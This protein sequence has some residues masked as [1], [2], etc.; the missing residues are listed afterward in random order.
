MK[1]SQERKLFRWVHIILSIPIFGYIY[2]PLSENIQATK[3]IRGF[4][5]PV[6]FITGL[7]MWKGQAIKRWFK[8]KKSFLVE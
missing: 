5:V 7:W 4:C 8:K 6:I 3:L 1:A 2:G